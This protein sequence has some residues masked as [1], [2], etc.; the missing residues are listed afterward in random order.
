MVPQ[1]VLFLASD[2]PSPW[3][4]GEPDLLS[5]SFSSSSSE[6]SSG[7]AVVARED[8]EGR[9]RLKGQLEGFLEGEPELLEVFR[10]L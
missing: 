9:E 5:F 1:A 4:P 3:K 7:Y 2:L 6:S 10:C 8:E